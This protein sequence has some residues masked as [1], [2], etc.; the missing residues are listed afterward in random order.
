M[1]KFKASKRENEIIKKMYDEDRPM[2]ATMLHIF[3]GEDRTAR[4]VL[5]RLTNAGLVEHTGFDGKL[6]KHELTAKGRKYA[7]KL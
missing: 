5:S 1:S 6:R 3:V 2:I 4:N 7:S